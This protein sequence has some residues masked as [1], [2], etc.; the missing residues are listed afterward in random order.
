LLEAA[1]V[2]PM[3]KK[4]GT[5]IVNTKYIQ[6]STSAAA[7]TD[8]NAEKLLGIITEKV[9]NVYEI[10]GISIAN[11]LD[12]ILVVNTILL[13]ALSA[14]PENPVKSG[15][16]EKAIAS[17]LKEKYLDLNLKAFQIG[18]KQVNLG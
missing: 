15:A 3:I 1:R 14:L 5:V 10:D 12:N 4:D 17:R 11:R 13:G 9:N 6:P 7:S 16:F 8:L 18:R 2:L